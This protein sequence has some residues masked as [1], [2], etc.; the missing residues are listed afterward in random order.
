MINPRIGLYSQLEPEI[1][2]EIIG[3]TTNLVTRKL[4]C[5]ANTG[6]K[7]RF[8]IFLAL[9]VSVPLQA[10][11]IKKW[12]DEEGNVHYGD[13][14]PISAKTE[15]VRVLSAPTNPGKAL[16]RLSSPGTEDT[17]G[18]ATG[19]GAS[20]D[21]VPADQAKIACDR[22][23]EDLDVISRSNRIKLREA[24][25]TERYMSTEEIEERRALAEED[26]KQFCK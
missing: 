5:T 4:S 24:D 25:G 19:G 15:N 2:P 12:V 9:L 13:A 11:T 17:A 1:Q 14:P 20:D 22:A 10:G 18:G 6:R 16:P 7:M 21:Q 8:L 23:R 26:V 3:M